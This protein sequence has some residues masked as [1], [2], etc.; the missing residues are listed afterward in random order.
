MFNTEGQQ[1]R[2]E[3]KKIGCKNEGNNNLNLCC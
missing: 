1:E 2:D 3:L